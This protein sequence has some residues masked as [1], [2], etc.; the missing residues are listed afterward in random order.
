MTVV[1]FPIDSGVTGTGAV[2]DNGGAVFNVKNLAFGA[3]GNGTPAGGG[4]DDTLALQKAIN[5]AAAVNG[6]VFLPSGN[7]RITSALTIP[8]S[9]SMESAGFNELFGTEAQS[10]GGYLPGLYPF[11]AGAVIIPSTAGQNAFTITATSPSLHLRRIA[12]RFADPIAFVNTG[13]GIFA[14]PSQVSGGGH[15]SG[16]EACRWDTVT[17]W[18]HDGNHYAYSLLNARYITAI[19]LRSF[20]G[21]GLFLDGDTTEAY[22]NSTYVDPYFLQFCAGTADAVTIS[23]TG[24]VGA[25]NLVAFFSPTMV[26][27]NS[28]SAP[29]NIYLF[30]GANPVTNYAWRRS[31][32]AIY[33]FTF[34][35]VFDSSGTTTVSSEGILGTANIGSSGPVGW[36]QIEAES[37]NQTALV[38]NTPPAAAV[39]PM[40]I[41]TNGVTFSV[42]PNGNV[43]AGAADFAGIV[44]Q[45]GIATDA[46]TSGA[47]SQP[48][49]VSGTPQQL[50]TTR[51]MTAVIA[52]TATLAAGTCAVALSPDNVTYTTAAT[53]SPGILNGVDSVAVAVPVN[54][55]LR[56]TFSNGTAVVTEY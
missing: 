2:L 27:L 16:L 54:W 38:I 36:L 53:L 21:G 24:G 26:V 50:S 31:T 23:A 10:F 55:R 12:I 14:A 46:I 9:V 15:E 56:L 17:V 48:A 45:A 30:T 43:A 13:H 52:F 29:Y 33:V 35:R 51:D 3:I 37:I 39:A 49:F 22:G 40:L 18:G 42:D 19:K 44:G 7:Y 20:G 6:T 34:A 5:A 32:N 28:V 4:A 47:L 25:V 8:S 41:F 1:G 11:I